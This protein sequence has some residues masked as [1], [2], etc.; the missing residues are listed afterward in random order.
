MRIIEQAVKLVS[1][2]SG[3]VKNTVDNI[4]VKQGDITTV[5]STKVKSSKE[6]VAKQIGSNEYVDK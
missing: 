3:H 6:R 5:Q 1:I 4:F 2:A